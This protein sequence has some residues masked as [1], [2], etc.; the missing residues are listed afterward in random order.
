MVG[1]YTVNVYTPN[2][3]LVDS[4]IINAE[5]NV[6]NYNMSERPNGVYYFSIS[7]SEVKTTRK[8]VLLR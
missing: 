3:S 6:Y 5:N 4:F 8:V 7:N 2:G 1:M